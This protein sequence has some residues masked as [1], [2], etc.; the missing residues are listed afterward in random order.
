MIVAKIQFI[1]KTQTIIIDVNW[2]ML[3]LQQEVKQLKNKC[4][5]IESQGKQIMLLT[6]REE[7]FKKSTV[8]TIQ[9]IQK[10]QTQIEG[11]STSM[12]GWNTTWLGMPNIIFVEAHKYH[13]VVNSQENFLNIG[14]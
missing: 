5:K 9:Q 6:G 10:T 14:K 8:E 11:P 2:W 1:A 7:R 4:S 13:E 3:M 12:E